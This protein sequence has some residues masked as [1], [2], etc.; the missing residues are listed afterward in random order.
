MVCVVLFNLIQNFEHLLSTTVHS[1]VVKEMDLN[2]M[3]GLN[4]TVPISVNRGVHN[5]VCTCINTLCLRKTP[6]FYLW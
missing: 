1:S 2:S 4:H 6:S 3:C 5:T